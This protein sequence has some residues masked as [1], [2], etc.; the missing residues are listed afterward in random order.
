[1]VAGEEN[2]DAV[3]LEAAEEREQGLLCRGVQPRR[4]FVEYE[5]VRAVSD[6]GDD[7]QLPLTASRES[8]HGLMLVLP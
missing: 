1:M 3:F 6:R 5:Q 7:V 2:A 4:R 8:A